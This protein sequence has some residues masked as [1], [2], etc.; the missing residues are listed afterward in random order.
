MF[1]HAKMTDL[2]GKQL[3]AEKAMVIPPDSCLPSNNDFFPQIEAKYA[4]P[5]INKWIVN[6]Y[7]S[8]N[9]KKKH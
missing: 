5:S 3:C 9:R 4:K 8:K 2:T 7:T 1:Y 6:P